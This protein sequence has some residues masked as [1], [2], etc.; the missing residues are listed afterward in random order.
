MTATLPEGT[1]GWKYRF[2]DTH[3]SHK[4]YGINIVTAGVVG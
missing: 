3:A 2:I 4:K 1:Y